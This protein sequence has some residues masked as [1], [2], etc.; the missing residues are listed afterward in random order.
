MLDVFVN[1]KSTLFV[2]NDVRCIPELKMRI[3]SEVALAE[4]GYEVTRVGKHVFVIKEGLDAARGTQLPGKGSM[5]TLDI[6]E[7]IM[8]K[9]T[10]SP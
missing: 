9:S 1:G 8:V 10:Q 5:F 4:E 6:T 2:Q 7:D 3:V